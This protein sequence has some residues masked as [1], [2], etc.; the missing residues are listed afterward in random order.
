[1]AMRSS[2]LEMG[3]VA[4]SPNNNRIVKS[5]FFASTIAMPDTVL[6]YLEWMMI[7]HD[8]PF[9]KELVCYCFY[10]GFPELA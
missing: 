10:A 2:L 5:G 1:M 6:K 3:N 8:H 7:F 4:V 9:A